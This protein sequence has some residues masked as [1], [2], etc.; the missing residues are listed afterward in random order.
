MISQLFANLPDKFAKPQLELESTPD[1]DLSQAM[2][3]SLADPLFYPPLNQSVFP[4]D[5]V[6]VALQDNLPKPKQIFEALLAQLENVNV[7]PSD[8]TLVITPKMANKFSISPESY[9]QDP[10]EE[11]PPAVFELSFGFHKINCQ[12][13]D[14]TNETG[15][16]YLV[17]NSDG[18][19]V[20][21]NRLLVDADI[22]IPVGFPVAGD[23]SD[24]KDCIYPDFSSESGIARLRN[25]SL[26][27]LDRWQEIELA[28]DTLGSFFCLQ[29]VCG[30]GESIRNVFAGARKDATDQ[31]RAATNEVWRFDWEQEVEMVV[32]TVES[33]GP[34]QSWQDILNAVIAASR[35]STG[36][37]I[38]VWS[39]LESKPEKEIR[40]ACLTQF[41]GDNN[42][43]LDKKI[44]HFVDILS[45][46]PVFLKS[47]LTRNSIEEL[48]IGFVDNV[49]QVLKISESHSSGLLIRDAHKCQI[50]VGA[51]S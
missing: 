22:V 14:V 7:E 43:K 18:E 17:A 3:E 16:S 10:S 13:H 15:L 31:A 32:A 4:G 42:P 37:P 50:R 44:R 1:I 6:A 12:V 40:K 35:V 21:I 2:Q 49:D 38:V 29:V 26:S 25:G 8:I 45:G 9:Q 48:G 39:E 36:G 19:P 47:N 28:N 23:A 11:K 20:T 30:P 33:N 27:F 34:E 51:E 46:R 5:T 41:D 24:Q